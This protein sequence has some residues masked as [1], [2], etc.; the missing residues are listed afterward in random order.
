VH[1]HIELSKLDEYLWGITSFLGPQQR[2]R[3]PFRGWLLCCVLVC[4]CDNFSIRSVSRH[5]IIP[6]LLEPWLK[7]GG[8]T[9]E[10]VVLN[11]KGQSDRV[12]FIF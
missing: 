8:L 2:Q 5:R 10:G 4:L 6:S 11:P 7:L 9:C 1:I 3:K 12:L